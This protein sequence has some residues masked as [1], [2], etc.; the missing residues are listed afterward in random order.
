MVD[1]W[2]GQAVGWLTG[3]SEFRSFDFR[4]FGFRFRQIYVPHNAKIMNSGVISRDLGSSCLRPE[5]SGTIYWDDRSKMFPQPAKPMRHRPTEGTRNSP[6]Q[7]TN[8]HEHPTTK[9]RSQ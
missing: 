8:V 1:D 9:T 5:K 7:P 2:L 4:S 3:V 6:S